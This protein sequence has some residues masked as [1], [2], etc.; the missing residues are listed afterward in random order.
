MPTTRQSQQE[1]TD[2]SLTSILKIPKSTNLTALASKSFQ[3]SATEN[4][5]Q[6]TTLIFRVKTHRLQATAATFVTR[7]FLQVLKAMMKKQV[8][9]FFIKETSLL[10]IPNVNLYRLIMTQYLS[11]FQVCATWTET[12]LNPLRIRKCCLR[13]MH[14]SPCITETL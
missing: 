2:V 12:R 13:L 4:T 8:K 3:A 6:V 11:K 7:H 1:L 9:L 5:A 10:T 14:P